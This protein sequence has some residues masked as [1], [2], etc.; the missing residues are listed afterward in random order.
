MLC[1]RVWLLER[2][3]YS[4]KVEQALN[5]L[6]DEDYNTLS[7]VLNKRDLP[8]VIRTASMRQIIRDGIKKFVKELRKSSSSTQ[9]EE[10]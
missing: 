9:S 7:I 3:S 6:R 10:V 2:H 4:D 1:F 5:A 8:S